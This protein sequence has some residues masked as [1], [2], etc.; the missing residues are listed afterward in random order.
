MGERWFSD[1]QLE[2]MSRPT[3]DRAVEAID[4]G[5]LQQARRLCT[6]MKH[7]WQMLHDL[8]AAQQDTIKADTEIRDIMRRQVSTGEIARA[9]LLAQETVLAQAQQALIPLQTQM[10][11]Q[12]HLL[13]ALTGGFP[14]DPVPHDFELS[15]LHLPRDLP[16]SISSRQVK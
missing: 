5:D 4:A 1:D 12:R 13:A 7:E 2:Q 15:S 8:M 3:M 14:S 16:V 10:A 11:Q 9:D 6:E